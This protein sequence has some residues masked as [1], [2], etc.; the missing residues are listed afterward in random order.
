MLKLN[1]ATGGTPRITEMYEWCKN[2]R[3]NLEKTK[4]N[5]VNEFEWPV[6]EFIDK[7]F[8]EMKGT[9]ASADEEYNYNQPC[10]SV[11]TNWKPVEIPA[12]EPAKKGGVEAEDWMF[13]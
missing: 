12:V 3:H 13:Y 2:M 10:N 9:I 6:Q 8:S 1:E 4:Y 7:H 5:S 11:L